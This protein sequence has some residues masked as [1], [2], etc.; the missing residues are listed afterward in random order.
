[1]VEKWTI[2]TSKVVDKQAASLSKKILFILRLL[3]EDLT[4]KGP[5]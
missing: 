2:K 4:Y 5:T 3:F 1:M